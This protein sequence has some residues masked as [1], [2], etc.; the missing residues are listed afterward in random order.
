MNTQIKIRNYNPS[1]DYLWVFAL[2]NNSETY[3]WQFDVARDSKDKLAVFSKSNPNK[4]LIAEVE[5]KIIGT[6]TIFEDG[7][8]A[9]LY[10]FA[11]IPNY[12]EEAG[13]LLYDHATSIAKMMW[14]AQM[15]VYGPCN[16]QE[17]EDRYKD[18][19]F[20]KWSTF[21]AYRKNI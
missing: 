12:D 9:W 4:L 11:L 18:L 7:R 13:K 21:T 14:H 8:S 20:N 17:I 19:W 10:R 5:W 3:W 15:I 1:T 2:Y 6:V 16:N